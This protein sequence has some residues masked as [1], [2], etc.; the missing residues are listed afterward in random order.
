MLLA[1]VTEG[2]ELAVGFLAIAIADARKTVLL[3]AL[4]QNEHAQPSFL[5]TDMKIKNMVT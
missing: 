1:Q 5:A 2:F 3:S 4:L